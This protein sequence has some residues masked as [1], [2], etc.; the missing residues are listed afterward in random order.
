M[1]AT[2]GGPMV[3]FGTKW[4][5]ITSTWRRSATGATQSMALAK[6]AKSAERMDGAMRQGVESCTGGSLRTRT[7]QQDE[8]HPVGARVLRKQSCAATDRLPWP[9]GRREGDQFRVTIRQ[10]GIDLGRLR[11]GQ[12]AHA[13]G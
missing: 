10:P 13:V 8:K 1:A 7:R 11:G 4:P 3:R 6:A 9:G 5:S 2:T 12:C